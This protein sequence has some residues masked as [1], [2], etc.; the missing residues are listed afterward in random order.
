MTTSLI[1]YNLNDLE[2]KAV[3]SESQNLY[4]SKLIT[5]DQWFKIREAF[6]S[7]L[8]SP[9][10]FMRVLLFIAAI[11]GFNSILVPIG[12]TF[13]SIG[14]IGYRFLTLI[15]GLGLLIF[16]EK[17]LIKDKLHYKSGVTEAGIYVGLG[18][19]A[20]A[21]LGFDNH[22]T[23]VYP[24]V[25]FVLAAFAAIRY[26]NLTAL[27][28]TF[29]FLGWIEFQLLADINLMALMPF[30]FIISFGLI[31]LG[32]LKLK[33]KLSNIVFTSHFIIVE[34]IA[35]LMIY[36]AGNY[37]VVRELS[38]EMM[39]LEI[40]ENGNIP[41]AYLFYLFTALIPIAYIYWGIKQ[42]L[43]LFIRVG[44]LTIALSVITLK[45]YFNLGQP[46]VTVTIAGAVLIILSLLL[47]NY[48]KQIRNGFTRDL[49]LNDKWN[50][51]D[52]AAFVAS[53]TLGG[54]ST[55]NSPNNDASF[56]DGQFGGAGAGG[57]W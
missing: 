53:Q 29:G 23:I 36:I 42:K 3:L 57:N 20:F 47:L 40:A 44:L 37:F 46:I 12:I 51:N 10:I 34:T 17:V 24:I 4:K 22:P 21:F 32:C 38:I 25:G 18:F 41:F 54:H 30:G 9:N 43:I 8:Y 49:L 28:L 19:L 7:D 2:T 35:L 48:L 39:N 50:S 1:A 31:Y 15:V 26:L 55:T 56:G 33:V 11:I 52:L 16:I 27:V 13:G 45:I 5:Q 14:E 6:K